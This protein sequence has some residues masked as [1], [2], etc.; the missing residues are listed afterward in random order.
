M[1]IKSLATT[2]LVSLVVVVAYNHY[3]ASAKH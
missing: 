3:A 1:S 2:A